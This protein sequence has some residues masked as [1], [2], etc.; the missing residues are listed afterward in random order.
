MNAVRSRQPDEGS[1]SLPHPAPHDSKVARPDPDAASGS[2]RRGV[3]MLLVIVALGLA[4]VLSVTALA[5]R[6]NSGA[7][8]DN[9]ASAT[10][11]A[12]SAKSAADIG[13][14]LMQTPLD[15]RSVVAGGGA[16]LNNQPIAGGTVSIVVTNLAG[17]PPGPD[18]QDLIMAVSSVVGG[19]ESRV[20]RY[21]RVI[22]TVETPG[23][24]VD[25]SLSEFTVYAVDELT[26]DSGTAMGVWS[27][28][29]SA[30]APIA[31]KIGLGFTS[32][33]GLSVDPDASIA[34]TNLYLPPGAAGGT[35]ELQN[36][37]WSGGAVL[38]AAIP[39]VTKQAE[40]GFDALPLS[41]FGD[42]DITG[43]SLSLP[44]KKFDIVKIR[45]G[46]VVTI[47]SVNGSHYS[48]EDLTIES[49]SVVTIRGD[50]KIEVRDDFRVR[51]RSALELGTPTATLTMWVFDN[52]NVE[53]SS[54][55]FSRTVGFDPARSRD[56]EYEYFS[57]EQIAIYGEFRN[58]KD[59]DTSDDAM[60]S[61]LGEPNELTQEFRIKKKSLVTAS[62][63]APLAVAKI[64]DSATLFGRI[65]VGS[66]EIKSGGAVLGDTVL[67]PGYGFTAI[68]GPLY[69]ESGDLNPVLS[70]VFKN[71]AALSDV[72]TL[73]ALSRAAFVTV[74]SAPAGAGKPGGPSGIVS[75]TSAQ[76]TPRSGERAIPVE[77]PLRLAL[78]ESRNDT[79]TLVNVD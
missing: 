28:S 18:D 43:G 5:S 16:L 64:E 52:I 68:G 9:A 36:P 8:G 35:T 61:S 29:P 72:D 74:A 37:R 67:D 55:G 44:S 30:G 39:S 78:M 27:K 21:V 23:H 15:W 49:G 59:G 45:N 24:A 75:G 41:L 53:D 7:L 34:R 73:E 40:A 77:M 32:A 62:I 25:G 26:V 38:P 66:L 63:H 76:P 2:R 12:W 57:P 14:A 11:A 50:V 54:V 10:R 19:V 22:P 71:P 1:R 46:S 47:D 13:I 33:S 42:L 4:T 51:G 70:A 31:A 69:T 20:V 79:S 65:T 17:D 56:G 58:D 48:F 3:A 60:D 6:G